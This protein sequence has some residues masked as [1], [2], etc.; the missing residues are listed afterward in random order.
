MGFTE[1]HL[2]LL[3]V[4]IELNRGSFAAFPRPWIVA[5]SEF[6]RISSSFGVFMCKSECGSNIEATKI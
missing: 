3:G 1:W 5:F 6:E 2:G 4:F